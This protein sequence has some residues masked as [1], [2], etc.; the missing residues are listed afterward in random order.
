MRLLH[1]ISILPTCPNLSLIS[2]NQETDWTIWIS[3]LLQNKHVLNFILYNSQRLCSYLW[4]L[5]LGCSSTWRM[6][7]LFCCFYQNSADNSYNLQ[8]CASN[9]TWQKHQIFM[10]FRTDIYEMSTFN[11]VQSCWSGSHGESN[12][13]GLAKFKIYLNLD[14]ISFDWDLGIIWIRFR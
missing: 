6:I 5:R 8:C 2:A 10:A 4:L 9:R 11:I 3:C 13:Q 12:G 7:I 1:S 14:L